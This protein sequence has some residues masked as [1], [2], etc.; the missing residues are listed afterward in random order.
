MRHCPPRRS[1][2]RSGLVRPDRPRTTRSTRAVGG[3]I[4]VTYDAHLISVMFDG[5]T[6]ARAHSPARRRTW[7]PLLVNVPSLLE[8]AR[9]QLF[10]SC[11]AF[12]SSKIRVQT[13]QRRF[14]RTPARPCAQPRASAPQ[15]WTPATALA[16][17]SAVGAQACELL[18]GCRRGCS[19]H[20][21]FTALR[22]YGVAQ[23]K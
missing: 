10:H 3:A 19:P 9:S 2:E 6:L 23:V 5:A 12:D 8:R 15:S 22:V 16:A 7:P 14:K 17:H 4:E 13:V 18:P 11:A 21:R 20:A 1:C